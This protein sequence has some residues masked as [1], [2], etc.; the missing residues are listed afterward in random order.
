MQDFDANLACVEDGINSFKDASK[1]DFCFICWA[2][3]EREDG[4]ASAQAGRGEVKLGRVGRETGGSDMH[5]ELSGNL[6]CYCGHD[7]A[8]CVTYLATKY[9]DDH[10]RER[11]QSFYKEQFGLE[12]P[13]EAFHCMG[14]RAEDVFESCRHCPFARCCKAHKVCFCRDCPEY[15]C[16]DIAAYQAQYVNRCNQI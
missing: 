6:L 7:C 5:S 16:A 9:D 15:P 10:L 4:D 11:S 12:L 3:I 14:G 2:E 13:L 1:W 8:K